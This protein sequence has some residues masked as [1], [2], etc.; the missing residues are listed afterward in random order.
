MNKS[1][2]GLLRSA[3]VSSVLV[4]AASCDNP[5]APPAS[6][7]AR[8]D[9]NEA[10]HS[11]GGSACPGNSG[12]VCRISVTA[13]INGAGKAVLVART[14][15]FD[16]ATGE[17]DPDGSF[18]KVQWK[19]YNPKGKLVL[20]KNDNDVNGVVFVTTLP[21]YVD[22][23]YRIDVEALIKSHSGKKGTAV[24]RGTAVPVFAPDIDLTSETIELL[25]DGGRQPLTTVEPNSVNTYVVD[26]ANATTFGGT[27]STL[28]IK[29][30]CVVR[31]DGQLQFAGFSPGFSYVGSP[32]QYIGPGESAPCAFT[33][34]LSDG[35]HTIKVTAVA[36]D[37]FFDWSEHNNST[38][39]TV[40]AGSV[41]PT[42]TIDLIVRSIERDLGND[43][44]EPLGEV[45]AGTPA[46]Y[47]ARI[48]ALP[49]VGTA[50]SANATC[51][52]KV[53]NVRTGQ[54]VINGLSGTVTGAASSGQDALCRFALT[55]AGNALVDEPYRIEATAQ[56]INAAEL[57]A[58]NNTLSTGVA[59]IVRADVGLGAVQL[60]VDGVAQTDLSS[61]KQGK[62]GVFTVSVANPS[63]MFPATV[64]CGAT[65][66]SSGEP[67]VSI[68]L[69]GATNPITV[70]PGG[71]ATCRFD[72][73]FTQ[74]S[75]VDFT[76]TATPTAPVDPELTNNTVSFSTT[77][78][79]DN[80]FPGIDGSN[81][82]A[83]QQWTINVATG[84]PTNLTEQKAH[85]R[86]ITLA[87]ANA[88]GVIGDFKLGG[89]IT[90]AGRTLSQATW[91]VNDL[92]SAPLD[93]PN[94]K[95]G[96]DAN[97][98]T[99]NNHLVELRICSIGRPGGVQEIFVEYEIRTVTSLPNPQPDNL[100]ADE[101]TFDV[102]LDW[103]LE[104]SSIPDHAS[105]QISFGLVETSGAFAHIRVKNHT[106]MITVIRNGGGT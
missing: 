38:T 81:I 46:N 15:A 80:T 96:V 48:G 79:S 47:L 102:N 18:D 65:A 3:A 39:A 6:E 97:P 84:N 82:F 74:L 26:I 16:Q 37:L 28:G 12:G 19:I 91:T 63:T 9:A 67:A 34:S 61:V 57:S 51:S 1:I 89:K 2:A 58:G 90:T 54:T 11:G 29:S 69:V 8:T 78:L 27:P 103:T 94:C 59:A 86:Q 93:A 44:T 71:S 104:G 31:V 36:Q 52:V 25:V 73:T 72:Y 17:Q 45:E 98:T 76:I 32:Y 30:L 77:V 24:V 4:F 83:R 49:D 23:S 21:G 14:G 55:L 75:V 10:F 53:L 35:A 42:E 33:L 13:V 70:S 43:A 40:V 50:T 7:L 87:F 64:N 101:L 95:N 62:T 41:T 105:A 92:M 68:P 22:A 56:P 100:F 99:V 85:I 88:N 106:G 20:T 60:S 5:A 66:S